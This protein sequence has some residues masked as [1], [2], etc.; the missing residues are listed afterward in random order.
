MAP[1][2][3]KRAASPH[4]QG[5]SDA[6]TQVYL[7]DLFAGVVAGSARSIERLISGMKVEVD[8]DA[9]PDASGMN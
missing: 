2:T 9:G 7:E 6:E 1:V 8:S 4:D 3:S 5:R